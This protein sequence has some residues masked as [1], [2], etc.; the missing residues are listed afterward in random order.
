MVVSYRDA[1]PGIG[2]VS[3]ST[4]KESG[5]ADE[6]IFFRGGKSSPGSS[7][8]GRRESGLAVRD[9]VCHLRGPRESGLDVCAGVCQLRGRRKNGLAAGVLYAS[10]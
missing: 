7:V 4:G 9:G 6:Y 2:I 1:V 5:A 10:E 8:K 3:V